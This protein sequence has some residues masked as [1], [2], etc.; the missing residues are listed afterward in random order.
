MIHD[1]LIVSEGKFLVNIHHLKWWMFIMVFLKNLE[2]GGN[3][4]EHLVLYLSISAMAVL[5]VVD[6]R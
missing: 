1:N 6:T 3:L 4:E 2:T 5:L